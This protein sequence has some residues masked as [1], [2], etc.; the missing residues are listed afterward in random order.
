MVPSFVLSKI[1]ALSPYLSVPKSMTRRR[2]S[3][4]GLNVAGSA[5]VQPVAAV[6]AAPGNGAWPAKPAGWSYWTPNA[7]TFAAMSA[8][9]T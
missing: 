3:I 6:G 2:I 5:P 1:Q 8:G 4:A 7:A 9:E